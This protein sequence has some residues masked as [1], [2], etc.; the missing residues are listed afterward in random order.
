MIEVHQN[1]NDFEYDIHSLVRAF[2]PGVD[3][4]VSC[5]EENAGQKAAGEEDQEECILRIMITYG[6]NEISICLEEPSGDLQ[7]SSGKDA[8]RKGSIALGQDFDRAETKNVLKQLLYDLLSAYTGQKLPW[9]N[10]TGI[11][12]TKI[13]MGLLEKGWK[14]TEIAAYMRDK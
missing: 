10:L 8:A 14:N 1:K 7:E 2:Y 13:P 11:R 9:G 5:P 6:D 12:P 4:T 3:V